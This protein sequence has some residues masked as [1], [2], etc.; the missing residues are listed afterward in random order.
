MRNTTRYLTLIVVLAVFCITLIPIEVRAESPLWYR[1]CLAGKA[2]C[3]KG[4]YQGSQ[5]YYL[6]AL[7]ELEKIAAK[8]QRLKL[9]H[10][11]HYT[12]TDFYCNIE[13]PFRKENSLKRDAERNKLK[14]PEVN[15]G[16]MLDP[17]YKKEIDDY[18]KKS[19]SHTK[20]MKI[21]YLQDQLASINRTRRILAVYK[22]LLGPNH[23][24]TRYCSD[25]YKNELKSYQ[26]Q[27]HYFMGGK[28]KETP[29]REK[30]YRELSVLST[31]ASLKKDY[32][33]SIKYDAQALAEAERV[34]GPESKEVAETLCNL[35]STQK[36]Y[37]GQYQQAEA[38]LKRALAIKEKIYGK[39]STEV[40]NVLLSLQGLYRDYMGDKEKAK[41][42]T[43]RMEEMQK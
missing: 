39:N 24:V 4:D 5:R 22:V 20:K 29:E 25:S 21:G 14:A 34:F 12:L 9:P 18:L 38:N 15:M 33:T 40:F 8:G 37:L 41:P 28:V 3:Q 32:L 16:R 17:N 11:Q 13:D 42:Y 7:G 36:I 6:G 2:Y 31:N 1:Y 35:G 19:D 10:K 30:R 23:Q 27:N 26:E 43:K